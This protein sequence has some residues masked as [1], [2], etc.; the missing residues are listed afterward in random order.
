MSR[1]LCCSLSIGL[2]SGSCQKTG[3]NEVYASNER[4]CESQQL[5]SDNGRKI[6][7]SQEEGRGA[8][9]LQVK[10][11]STADGCGVPC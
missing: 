1:M 10:W 6:S 2:A 3:R 4:K 8:S 9:H 5:I 11:W 7:S